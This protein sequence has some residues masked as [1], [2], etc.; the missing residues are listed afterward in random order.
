MVEAVARPARPRSTSNP[1]ELTDPRYYN[2]RWLELLDE[3]KPRIESLR[4]AVL[5]Q[6]GAEAVITGG[7]GQLASDLESCSGAG[8]RVQRSPRAELDVT[9]DAAMGAA[10]D[11]RRPDLVFNCAAFH[12]V[13][14]CETEEDAGSRRERPAP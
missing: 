2:I 14:E 12:N 3:L 9:D 11:G 10:F 4:L 1:T 7:A 13:E 6:C 5:G 8:G